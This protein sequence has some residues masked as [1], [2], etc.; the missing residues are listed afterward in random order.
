[1]S[2]WSCEDDTTVTPA[3]SSG[4]AAQV[5]VETDLPGTFIW[6]KTFD[7]QLSQTIT[8]QSAGYT[9]R[10]TAAGNLF[11]IYRNNE[12]FDSFP[13][14]TE[15]GDS[16]ENYRIFRLV[17]ADGGRLRY[18]FYFTNINQL[19]LQPTSNP[20]LLEEYRRE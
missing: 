15:G 19:F 16:T 17:N 5:A 8:P 1:M 9:E 2:G 7:S 18:T 14:V 4:T 10:I 12:L 20:N 13:F 3:S 11:S 6:V